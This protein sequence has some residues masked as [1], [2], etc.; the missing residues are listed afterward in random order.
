MIF[1]FR[2]LRNAVMNLVNINGLAKSPDIVMPVPD[3]VRDDGSGIQ[4][5]LKLLDSGFRRNDGEVRKSAF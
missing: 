4:N 3:Q 5:P 1:D 2:L